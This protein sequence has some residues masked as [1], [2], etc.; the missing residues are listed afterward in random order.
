MSPT[1]D[2]FISRKCSPAGTALLHRAVSDPDAHLL[3]GCGSLFALALEVASVMSCA[4][5]YPWVQQLFLV[6]CMS[7]SAPRVPSQWCGCWRYSLCH[8]LATQAMSFPDRETTREQWGSSWHWGTSPLIGA[9]RGHGS[10][11]PLHGA[12]IFQEKALLPK[13]PKLFWTKIPL[14]FFFEVETS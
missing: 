2:I 14:S 7:R 3:C 12:K 13:Y 10:Q 4:L 11:N 6:Y 1:F 8:P 5:P 9:R